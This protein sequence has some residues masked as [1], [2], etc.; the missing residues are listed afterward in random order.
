MHAIPPPTRRLRL[1]PASSAPAADQIAGSLAL[2]AGAEQTGVPAMRWYEFAPPAL[3]LGSAQRPET[4]DLAAC[5]AAGLPVHR[6]RSGGG[7]VL[8]RGLLSL[9]LALPLADPLY[10]PDVSESYR[11]FGAVWA[12]ALGTLGITAQLVAIPHA[13]ADTQA[14]DPLLRR[15]CFAG[16]SPYEVLVG[17]RKLVGLAQVRRRAAA[18]FQAGI[19]LR[20]EP[21]HTAALIAATTAQRGDIAEQL[22]TRVMGL[23]ALPIP[24]PTEALIR[25]VGQALAELGGLRGFDDDWSKFE[26]HEYLVLRG[27]YGRLVS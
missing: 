17:P 12:A 22:A 21:A 19:Y 3:L 27:Q 23:D 24:P 14:L 10:T 4:V 7:A 9:D 5:A 18:L 15:V 8:T 6:R 2:L 26:R 16:L 20:W 11:W 13:R 25:A 1:L